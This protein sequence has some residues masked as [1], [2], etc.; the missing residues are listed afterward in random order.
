[1]YLRR[2]V[3]IKI[4]CHFVIQTDN[5]GSEFIYVLYIDSFPLVSPL[6]G[7]NNALLL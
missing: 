6:L 1:M 4:A 2:C 5:E 3:K 7:K